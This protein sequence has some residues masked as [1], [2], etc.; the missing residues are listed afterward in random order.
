MRAFTL[1]I[2]K[3]L[4][5]LLLL[6]LTLVSVSLYAQDD[7][8]DDTAVD[9]EPDAPSQSG[10]RSGYAPVSSNAR[11]DSNANFIFSSSTSQFRLLSYKGHQIKFMRPIGTHLFTTDQERE[12][13]LPHIPFEE[14]VLGQ[15]LTA[16]VR[17]GLVRRERYDEMKANYDK[18]FT[19]VTNLAF[20]KLINKSEVY[21]MNVNVETGDFVMT[22]EADILRENWVVLDVKGVEPPEEAAHIT[23]WD[24]PEYIVSTDEVKFV[25]RGVKSGRII[26]WTPDSFYRCEK[27]DDFSG[28]YFMPYVKKRTSKLAVGRNYAVVRDLLV[29]QYNT[30]TFLTRG[31]VIKYHGQKSFSKKMSDGKLHGKLVSVF[32]TKGDTVFVP[33]SAKVSPGKAVGKNASDYDLEPA[34]QFSQRVKAENKVS[35]RVANTELAD[36]EMAELNSDPDRREEILLKYGDKYGNLIIE[37]KICEGMTADMVHAAWGK[38][39]LRSVQKNGQQT[40]VMETFPNLNWVKFRNGRVVSFGGGY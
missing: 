26:Y 23:Q 13:V 15:T 33:I 20:P 1:V 17:S 18:Y 40:Q 38:A 27:P 12:F 8:A 3:P 6:V 28:V 4:R 29:D 24:N 39:D 19:I 30:T 10:G 35:S 21:D 32:S 25:L 16:Q 5:L 34:G 2:F 22:N 14:D 37:G 31:E 36:A 7:E 11:V 9:T